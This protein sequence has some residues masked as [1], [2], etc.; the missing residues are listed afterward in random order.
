MRIALLSG[1]PYE[2]TKSDGISSYVRNLSQKLAGKGHSVVVIT[3]G[4]CRRLKRVKIGE[5][6]VFE[7]PIL[8]VYPFHVHLHSVLVHQL[9]RRLES[10]LD[11]VHA[12]SP[13]VPAITTKLPLLTTIHSL[14]LDKANHYHWSDAAALKIS[15]SIFANLETKLFRNSDMLTAVA[16]HI[17]P[18]LRDLYRIDA[19]ENIVGNGVDE[20]FFTPLECADAPKQQVLYVGSLEPAKGTADLMSCAEYVIKR[21]PDVVFTLVGDG[22]S[23][24]KLQMQVA[25]LGL[26]ENVLFTGYIKGKL[27]V[28]TYQESA[29]FVMA[30]RSEGLSTTILEAMSCALPVVASSIA[31][32]Q[33]LISNGV[34]GYLVHTDRPMEMGEAVLKLLEDESIRRRMGIAARKMIEQS[35]TWERVSQRIMKCYENLLG[36]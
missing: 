18:K 6:T 1:A 36:E 23:R 3:R 34:N 10:E 35:Y 15:A 27:L 28:R 9:L 16:G 7:V 21:R 31:G 20:Q 5:I 17:Y 12:H 33:D 11:L 2:A 26:E 8:P 14:T 32:Q 19:K 4:S 25:K 29:M 13:Y 22:P 30:S 24:R